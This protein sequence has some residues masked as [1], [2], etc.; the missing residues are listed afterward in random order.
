MD[1]SNKSELKC[2]SSRELRSQK[3]FGPISIFQTSDVKWSRHLNSD[4]IIKDKANTHYQAGTEAVDQLEFEKAV[5]CFTKAIALQSKQAQLYAA[6]AKAYLQL[7]DFKSAALDYRHVCYLE[8]QKKEHLHHLAFVYYLQGQCYCDWGMFFEALES[9][10]KA[11]ELKPDVRPYHMRSLACLTA[12]GCYSDALRMVT[13]WLENETSSADLFTLRARLHHQLNQFVPCYYD[14]KAALR[15]N[16]GCPGARALL[17]NMEQ[18]ATSSYQQAVT[19]ALEGELSDALGII[20]TAVEL[21]PENTQ[22]Y[23]FRGTLYRKLKDFTGAIEDLMLAVEF[24]NVRAEHSK[25]EKPEEF[26]SLEQDAHVQLVL[27]YNDFAVQ[28]FTQGFYSKATKL[29]TNAIQ[30]H[31]DESRLFINRGDC[32]FRQK[33]WLFALADYQQAEEL[34]SQN[35]AIWLRLA[36]IH[37]TLGL[38]SYENLNFQDAADKFS[39]AIK[40]NP[41]VAQFYGNRVKA[42]SKMH[43]MEEATQDAVCALILDPANDELVPLLLRLFPGCSLSD[44]ISSSMAQTVKTQLKERIQTWRLVGFSP[45]RLSEKLEDI[46]LRHDTDRLSETDSESALNQEDVE[47]GF[48]PVGYIQ[49]PSRSKE[50]VNKVVKKLMHQRQSL[51]YTGP[52]IAPLCIRHNLEP[53]ARTSN[54]PYFWRKFGGLGLNCL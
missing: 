4:L 6:R 52:R 5:S 42:L 12:L 18:K 50:Q 10:A 24:C 51:S 11:V 48:K 3:L 32:F 28:C 36:I 41:G 13:N 38:H 45:S 15:F 2:P 35:Q 7:C 53:S 23:L 25:M 54:R 21:N 26:K 22:Y 37:N 9:F 14:L 46:D 43:R 8:P 20:T 27:T 34:D 17:E 30:E 39:V 47:V 33:E 31:R 44:V 40:Y 49:I 29:L 16:P 19:K 1:A